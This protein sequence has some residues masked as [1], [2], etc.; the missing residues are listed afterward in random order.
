MNVTAILIQGDGEKSFVKL[1]KVRYRKKSATGTNQW[2]DWQYVEEDGKPKEF[3]G[4][5][6]ASEVHQVILTWD[7]DDLADFYLYLVR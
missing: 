3:V 6:N 1:F 2:D 7:Y 4:P 5:N